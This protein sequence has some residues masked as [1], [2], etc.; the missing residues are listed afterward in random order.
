[1]LPVRRLQHVPDLPAGDAKAQRGD[2]AAGVAPVARACRA[3]EAAVDDEL[4]QRRRTP[5]RGDA[6]ANKV[7]YSSQPETLTGPGGCLHVP[8]NGGTAPRDGDNN[9]NGA[10]TGRDGRAWST[11]A[12]RST[13]GLSANLT[14]VVVDEADGCALTDGDGDPT[15]VCPAS[16]ASPPAYVY[17]AFHMVPEKNYWLKLI[18]LGGPASV[19]AFVVRDAA[20]GNDCVATVIGQS[21]GATDEGDLI[22]PGLPVDNPTGCGAAGTRLGIRNRLL[23]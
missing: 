13:T 16:S 17:C 1:M 11:I 20:P 19:S 3:A 4:L 15:I 22:L 7:R 5:Y 8:L 2:A 14:A 21:Q 9:D 6:G 12:W 18:N 23:P 10:P